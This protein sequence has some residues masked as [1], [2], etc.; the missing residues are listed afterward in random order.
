M[1][2]FLACVD[3]LWR[4]PVGS[5]LL[6]WT[7]AGVHPHW[8]TPVSIDLLW[9]ML[10]SVDLQRRTMVVDRIRDKFNF[11][12]NNMQHVSKP[13]N[14]SQLSPHFRH[15]RLGSLVG[16]RCRRMVTEDTPVTKVSVKYKLCRVELALTDSTTLADYP[17][18]PCAAFLHG[19]PQSNRR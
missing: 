12:N 2:I 5:N 16:G 9:W 1:S 18:E 13:L 8:W 3:L 19:G 6:R 14:T 11:S 4:I 15:G 17:H 7:I 10:M